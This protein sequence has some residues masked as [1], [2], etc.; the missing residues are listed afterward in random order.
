M[1]PEQQLEQARVSAARYERDATLEDPVTRTRL[2]R[3]ALRAVVRARASLTQNR[4]EPRL[5][6]R[7]DPTIAGQL[8]DVERS[9][10]GHTASLLDQ[11]S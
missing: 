3:A 10:D 11:C 1:R 2:R 4:S 6:G 8:D 7:H 5:L 9:I